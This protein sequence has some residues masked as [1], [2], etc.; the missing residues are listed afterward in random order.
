M[1][2]ERW[3]RIDRLFESCLAL[4]EPA[5]RE[6]LARECDGDADLLGIVQG[7][8][9]ADGA[10]GDPLKDAVNA[11]AAE[12]ATEPGDHWQGRVLGAYR[13]ERLLGTGGMGTVF[14]ASR[15]D[16]EY[17]RRVAIKVLSNAFASLDER[18]RLLSERQILANLAHSNIAQLLDGGTTTEGA[19][20]LVMEYIEG[21]PID[22]YCTTNGLTL[23]ERLGLFLRVCD[24]VQYA[25]QN[26]VIHRDIKPG[27]ILVTSDG[28]PKLLDFGIAKLIDTSAMPRTVAVTMAAVRLLTPRHA[29]PEQIK[30][31]PVTTAS[32]VYSLG[33]LLFR[34]L[35]DRYPY[36]VQDESVSGMERAILETPPQRPSDVA[37]ARLRREFHGD[38][39]TVVLTA[40][41]KEPERRY[42]TVRELAH[43]INAYLTRRPISARP[44]STGYRLRKFV[45]RHT[46]SVIATA[47]TSAAIIALVT[48]YTLRLAEERDLQVRERA[49]AERVSQFMVDIFK[50][51]NPESGGRT[52]I[53]AHEL[54]D[55]SSA[56]I[57][58]ELKGEPLVAASL[59][60]AMG[61]AYGGLAMYDRS[62]EMMREAIALRQQHLG[63]DDPLVAEA[64][65]QLG[66]VLAQQAD[67]VG[68]RAELENALVIQRARLGRNA[69]AVGE[70]L[71][72]LAF[73]D[74]RESKYPAMLAALK[75]SLQIHLDSVG[76]DDPR[77]GGVYS[78]LGS[79]HW[80][81]GENQQA[82]DAAAH[83]LAI[84]ER[85]APP[86]NARLAGLIHNLGLIAWQM[87]EY[88][89]AHELY[90]RELALREAQLGPEH[91]NVALALYGLGATS[92]EMGNYREALGFYRRAAAIQEK[93]Y[94]PKSPYTA[95]TFGG[96]G[97]TLMEM[98]RF[99][100]ARE[101]LTRALTAFEAHLGPMHPDL[102]SPL[103]GLA[104]SAIAE[105]HYD[106]A[107]TLLER[108]LVIVEAKFAPDHPDVLRTRISLAGVFRASGEYAK[109]LEYF[110]PSLGALQRTLGLEHPYAADALCGIADTLAHLGELERAREHYRVARTNLAA[111][112]YSHRR[113][114]MAECLEGHAALLRK[115][116]DS[117]Q[118]VEPET[119][120]RQIRDWLRAAREDP[121]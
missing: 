82:H 7:M 21:V 84:E 67:Y 57:S 49:T 87:G 102:R 91:P 104:K 32:D 92:K 120:A 38:L 85:V 60:A 48:F 19:P 9:D 116:G 23:K 119:K 97:F 78:L 88:P 37:D 34:L 47:A 29:S 6:M 64:R 61:R 112:K 111:Q 83:A 53:T 69:L 58:S 106:E 41:R 24:A 52:E 3:Q 98:Q 45:E 5:R 50:D 22:E 66:T 71:M 73:V 55:R 94:G 81:V 96:I 72:R 110:E 11:C 14:L 2:P 31:L 107:R 25:H 17:E 35:T 42:P 108:A 75:E 118:A 121:L 36:A 16:S 54:L 4:P 100:A 101:S 86:N 105:G 15:S 68:G 74:M 8:L 65:Y 90:R 99:P 89:R 43:D 114:A 109:A 103:A 63:A 27:N 79:Y 113:I 33:V 13:I 76:P 115:A 40:L 39:D 26:L 95:M 117:V 18:R 77:T 30:G 51:A 12:V 20:Y 70:T 44:D 1:T 56:N 10:T 80:A 28:T 93:V 62:E 46:A 59:L